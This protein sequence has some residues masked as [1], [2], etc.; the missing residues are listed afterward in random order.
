MTGKK[1]TLDSAQIVAIIV[2]LIA[3]VLGEW[4]V[5]REL[6]QEQQRQHNQTI[7]KQV[8]TDDAKQYN[9]NVKVTEEQVGQA[10]FVVSYPTDAQGQVIMSTQETLEAQLEAVKAQYG[11]VTT[12]TWVYLKVYQ[13]K[14]LKNVND[15][16]YYVSVYQEQNATL[17]Q[18]DYRELTH[19][20]VATDG[21]NESGADAVAS[22]FVNSLEI[23]NAMA[24]KAV[25]LA[26]D[27]QMTDD[28]KKNFLANFSDGNWKKQDIAI[29][30]N[31]LCVNAVQ[32]V[33]LDNGEQVSQLTFSFEELFPIMKA[34]AVPDSLQEAYKSY[35]Q[36][37]AQRLQEKRVAISFDDGPRADTT[38]H[39]LDTLKQYGVHATFFIMGQHVPGNEALIQRMVQEGHQLGNHS[40]N[41]PL[42]TQI[43]AEK[44]H[45]QV[46]DTQDVIAQAS[47]GIRPTVLRPPYGGFNTT[48]ASQAGIALVNW[49]VDS[50][51]WKSRNASKIYH[52]IMNQVHDG[53]IILM[54]DIHEESMQALGD[55]LQ[56]LQ[57]QGYAVGSVEEL[58]AGQPM[59]PGYV[60]FDRTD[61]HLVE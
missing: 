28:Q 46:Y 22:I 47:G 18:T 10:H 12:P 2:L 3:I 35:Q 61:K 55:V 29:I 6:A 7:M 41:H 37:V 8:E 57:S 40:Y 27:K 54:H 44:V 52:E 42:L 17:T 9:E 25:L 13:V 36:T 33:T 38:P 43:S 31:G 58:M 14:A 15:V 24:K 53:A 26:A 11:G 21:T 19:Q 4:F 30:E 20:L 23:N 49:S 51:D 59:E 50:L 5:I 45:K 1:K 60:Y 48:V 39:I 56:G 16:Y 32:P 34:D